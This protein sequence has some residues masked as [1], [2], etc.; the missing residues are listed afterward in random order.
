[1][2]KPIGIV[3]EFRGDQKSVDRFYVEGMEEGL[4][5]IQK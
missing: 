3:E 1:M 4:R 5:E 2:Y